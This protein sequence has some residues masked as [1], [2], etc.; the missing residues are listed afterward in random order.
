MM[1]MMRVVGHKDTRILELDGYGH[2]IVEPS[3]PLILRE[4]KRINE[5]MKSGSLDQPFYVGTYT[6]GESEGI[7]KYILKN[8]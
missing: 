6:G 4:V 8:T 3:T 1:R 2:G 5:E 7:Y